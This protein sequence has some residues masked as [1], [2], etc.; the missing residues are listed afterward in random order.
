ML[1]HKID[2]IVLIYGGQYKVDSVGARENSGKAVGL[3]EE[4]C[5]STPR[6]LSHMTG[7]RCGRPEVISEY[8]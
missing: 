6:N 3:V 7:A 1:I 5:R 4:E 8:H 2:T